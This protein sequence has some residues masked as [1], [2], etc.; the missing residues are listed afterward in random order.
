MKLRTSLGRDRREM[1]KL[2]KSM[3]KFGSPRGSRKTRYNSNF[4]LHP[5]R[6]RS[7]HLRNRFESH[8]RTDA[9]LGNITP[10][11]RARNS[12]WQSIVAAVLLGATL[13]VH[14][15]SETLQEHL[16]DFF[17]NSFKPEAHHYLIQSNII[18]NVTVRMTQFGGGLDRQ[19]L[20]QRDM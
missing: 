11:D 12:V 10:F 20:P 6:P 5:R 14:E 7:F 3:R 13:E 8:R 1:L 9:L 4:N 19:S 17:T 2:R 16:I 15:D 18:I